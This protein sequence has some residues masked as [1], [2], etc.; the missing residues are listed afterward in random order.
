M[1]ITSLD[2]LDLNKVYSYSDYLNWQFKERLE[3]LRGKIALMSPAPNRRHQEIAIELQ[4]TIWNFLQN[5]SCKVFPAPFDVRLPKPGNQASDSSVYTVVQPDICV[6][7]DPAKLDEQGC[8]GAPDI[9]VEIL[10]PG[11]SKREMK[12]K[13]D[14]YEEAGVQEYWIV[15]P[16][17]RT[18]F[19]FVLNA[20][21]QFIGQQPLTDEDFLT[22]PL[23]P[24]LKIALAQVFAE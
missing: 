22:T 18:V 13:Y 6:V 5:K 15:S 17:E 11:N 7:C 24:G 8:I 23:L 2:Q 9:M 21:G 3:L 10:S 14:L 1:P 4:S 19:V 12:D 16:A 20:E